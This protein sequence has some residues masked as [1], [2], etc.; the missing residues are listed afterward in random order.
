MD[1]GEISGR[2]WEQRR[3][4]SQSQLALLLMLKSVLGGWWSLGGRR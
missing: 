3:G 2:D 1:V 4:E